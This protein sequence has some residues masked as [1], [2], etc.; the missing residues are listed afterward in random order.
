MFIA[1]SGRMR[2][3]LLPLDP[4]VPFAVGS[5][6]VPRLPYPFHYHPELE[7]TFI[8]SGSGLRYLGD[9]ISRFEDGDLCLVGSETPHCW[10]SDPARD[11]PIRQVVVQFAP[12]VF[13]RDFLD[14]P[15]MR[16][17]VELFE[18]ARRGLRFVGEARRQAAA[19]LITLC[20]P[21]LRPGGKLVR[22][23][24][25]L[26]FL[27]GTDEALQVATSAEVA[28]GAGTPANGVVAGAQNNAKV[29]T[30]LSYVHT[31]AARPVPEREVAEL[32]GLTPSAFSRFF[33]RAFGK[34]F[35]RYLSDL[36]V[37]HACRLLADGDRSVTEIAFDVG[38]RNLSNFNRR[39]LR[40]QGMT[41][42]SYRRLA[43]R[44]SG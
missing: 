20:D 27:A 33:R 25:L 23:L 18:R 8:H 29:R 43:R 32:V 17:I 9:S 1:E 16:P 38:F 26:E 12:T 42:T 30:V 5:D 10:E 34:P 22:L 3:E 15:P 14:L 11:E 39:F 6:A 41:P 24:S 4:L 21:A 36:R 7:L 31:N 28:L 2:R 40:A 44:L 19:E 35:V 37:S 13:G